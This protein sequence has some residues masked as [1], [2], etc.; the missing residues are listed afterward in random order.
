MWYRLF[1]RNDFVVLCVFVIVVIIT[2]GV[3]VVV[4]AVVI[5]SVIQDYFQ[6][7]CMIYI[8]IYT[9]TYIYNFIHPTYKCEAQWNYIVYMILKYDVKRTFEI[10]R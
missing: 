5:I 1:S 6:N 4:A 9:Y 10:I 2:V 7:I 3:G 8:Y